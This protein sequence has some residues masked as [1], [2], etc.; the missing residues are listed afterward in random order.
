MIGPVVTDS[1]ISLQKGD[2]ELQDFITDLLMF[3]KNL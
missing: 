1:E 3:L 2:S